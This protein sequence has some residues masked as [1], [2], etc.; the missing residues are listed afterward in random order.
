MRFITDP[1][2]ALLSTQRERLAGSEVEDR[3]KSATIAGSLIEGPPDN[4]A[5]LRRRDPMPDPLPG[6]L[7]RA[8]ADRQHWLTAGVGDGGVNLLVE[9]RDVYRPSALDEGVNAMRFA[10]AQDLGAG[11][12]LWAENRAQWVWKPAVAVTKRGRGLVVAFVSD[13]NFRGALDGGLISCSS[14]LFCAVRR[15][16]DDSTEVRGTRQARHSFAI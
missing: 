16:R 11:G 8:V 3:E 12:H 9:G 15:T 1:D 5:A 2:V 10:S 7:L 14:M 4:A 6:V 13:P